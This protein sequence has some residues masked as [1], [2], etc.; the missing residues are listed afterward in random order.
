MI[1]RASAEFA[2]ILICLHSTLLWVYVK[3]KVL[4]P[5]RVSLDKSAKNLY[6]SIM[7]I[8]LK[9]YGKKNLCP[10]ATLKIIAEKLNRLVSSC[11]GDS[12]FFKV[13]RDRIEFGSCSNTKFHSKLIGLILLYC[14]S[15][16]SANNGGVYVSLV[17]KED[18]NNSAIVFDAQNEKSMTAFD[19]F[20]QGLSNMNDVLITIK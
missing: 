2:I 17:C 20:I 16:H 19:N 1:L 14:S 8:E 13:V 15:T 4:R 12:G 5:A 3:Y 11:S 18:S 10:Q 7:Q 6:Y 9:I